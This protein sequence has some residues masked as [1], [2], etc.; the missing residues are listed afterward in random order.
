MAQE[1]LY[2]SSIWRSIESGLPLL[3]AATKGVSLVTDQRGRVMVQAPYGELTAMRAE[4]IV[5]E[6]SD[7]FDYRFAFVWLCWLFSAAVVVHRYLPRLKR[8]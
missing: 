5:P 2:T 8:G 4:V 6:R 1:Q 7:A 3:R